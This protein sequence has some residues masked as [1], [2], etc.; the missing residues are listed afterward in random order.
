MTAAGVRVTDEQWGRVRI[1]AQCRLRRGAWYRVMRLTPLEAVV[2]VN[3]GFVSVPRA[4]LQIASRPSQHWTLVPRPP[5]SVR[6]PTSWGARYLVC[7][8]CRERAPL[9][10]PTASLRCPH[11]NGVFEIGWGDEP[12]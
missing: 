9:S 3:H 12:F 5:N 4:S 7:P 1:D 10:K 11:C 2:D 8:N 6:L